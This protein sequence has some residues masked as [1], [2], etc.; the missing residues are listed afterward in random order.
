MTSLMVLQLI[1]QGLP[2][3]QNTYTVYMDNYFT[4]IP[5]FQCLCQ[6]GFGACGTTRLN[7]SK[8]L[9]PKALYVLKDSK[10]SQPW[11]TLYAVPAGPDSN[12]DIDSVLCIT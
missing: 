11:N 4:T 8:A 12:T 10:K 2:Q 1:Q 9:F 5:L 6:L 3:H 7:V